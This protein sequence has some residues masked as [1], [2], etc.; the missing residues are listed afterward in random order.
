M[1]GTD[2]TYDLKKVILK[3]GTTESPWVA[4]NPVHAAGLIL[5][6]KAIT[7][8]E[9]AAAGHDFRLNHLSHTGPKGEVSTP[10]TLTDAPISTDGVAADTLVV[11]LNL[12]IEVP[13]IIMKAPRV[14]FTYADPGED[15][16]VYIST[17]S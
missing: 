2:S 9:I 8:T 6:S 16:T 14:K 13:E 15:V 12:W 7:F 4:L 17:K 1:A 5:S 11:P 10:Q 3:N